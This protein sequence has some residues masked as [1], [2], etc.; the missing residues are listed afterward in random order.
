MYL[1]SVR[2]ATG[3]S[4]ILQKAGS[5]LRLLSFRGVSFDSSRFFRPTT[6]SEMPIAAEGGRTP[7]PHQGRNNLQLRG[8]VEADERSRWWEGS[9]DVRYASTS[10]EEA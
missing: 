7:P 4:Y 8:R 6:E 9:C 5:S 3:G 10:L 2:N 1:T